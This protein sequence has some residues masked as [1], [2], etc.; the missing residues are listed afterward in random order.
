MNH[1]SK[2]AGEIYFKRQERG[3]KFFGDVSGGFAD[4]FLEFFLPL[5][6]L[7]LLFFFVFF[8][9]FVRAVLKKLGLSPERDN[10]PQAIF[11]KNLLRLL[12]KKQP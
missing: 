2:S 3:L 7:N 9:N 12:L 10:F 11:P 4:P 5:F 1:F 6:V 8:C